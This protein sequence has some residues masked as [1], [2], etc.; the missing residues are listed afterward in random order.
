MYTC[1]DGSG[2]F[3]MQ[4]NVRLVALPPGI[5]NTGSVSLQSGTGAYT[6]LTGHGVDNGINGVGRISGT[7]VQP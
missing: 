5:G 3:N 7:M 1:A 4:K 2:T 6:G